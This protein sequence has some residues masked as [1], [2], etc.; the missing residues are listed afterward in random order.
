MTYWAVTIRLVTVSR[1]QWH[2]LLSGYH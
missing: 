1:H 2:D